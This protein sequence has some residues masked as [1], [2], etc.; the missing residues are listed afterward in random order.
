MSREQALMAVSALRRFTDARRVDPVDL[1]TVRTHQVQ[2]FAHAG[3]MGSC[4][5][6]FKSQPAGCGRL[7]SEGLVPRPQVEL[8]C[9]GAAVLVMQVPI[10]CRDGIGI[11]QAVLIAPL[12]QLRVA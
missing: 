10:G 8:E 4:R 2:R 3:G 12:P 6:I 1:F 7:R 11:E 9:P 5:R